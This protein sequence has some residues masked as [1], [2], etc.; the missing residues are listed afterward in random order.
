MR[1]MILVRPLRIRR[2]YTQKAGKYKARR[3]AGSR[4]LPDPARLARSVILVV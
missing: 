3:A 1:I 2:H 4:P